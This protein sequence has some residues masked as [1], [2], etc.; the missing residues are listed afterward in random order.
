LSLPPSWLNAGGVAL[1]RRVRRAPRAV[2]QQRVEARA[3][4]EALQVFL[5]RDARLQPRI[6]LDRAPLAEA[7]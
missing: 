6:V 7:G 3:V 1:L 5:Q 2:G 4:G